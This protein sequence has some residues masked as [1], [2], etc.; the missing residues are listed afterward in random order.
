VLPINKD[1][2]VTAYRAI[3]VILMKF[4]SL[5]PCWKLLVRL[6]F[7]L[8]C[9]I[10]DAGKLTILCLTPLIC[11]KQVGSWLICYVTEKLF[12]N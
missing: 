5:N 8:L 3:Y 1:V 2:F 12:F 6:Y 7:E 10:R 4:G 11:D 9:S